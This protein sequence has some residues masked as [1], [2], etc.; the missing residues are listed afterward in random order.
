[1]YVCCFSCCMAPGGICTASLLCVR[2]VPVTIAICRIKWLIVYSA[3]DC[4]RCWSHACCVE[5]TAVVALLYLSFC[6]AC[7]ILHNRMY[8]VVCTDSGGGSKCFGNPGRRGVPVCFRYSSLSFPRS[9][10]LLGDAWAS[11][12]GVGGIWGGTQSRSCV[13]VL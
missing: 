9:C 7:V 5:I 8:P 13:A 4:S 3:G 1:M 12:R 10:F 2:L 6:S 11:T